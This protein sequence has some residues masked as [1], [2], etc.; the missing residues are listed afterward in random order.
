[1]RTPLVSVVLPIYNGEPFLAAALDSVLEQTY[2][3]LEIIA[4]NDGSTDGSALVLGDY[5]SRVSIVT[6]ENTGVAGARNEG[7]KR[8]SG[9]YVCFIDQDDRWVPS[10]VERQL[11]LAERDC[12]LGLVHS[13][14]AIWD[15]ERQRIVEDQPWTQRT[16]DMTGYC[17]DRLMLGNPLCNSS[18]MV[19]KSALD[20]VGYCDTSITGNT[21]PDYDLWLRIAKHW[22]F[23]HIPERLTIYRTH[24]GQGQKNREAMLKAE[25][26]VLGKHRRFE[27]WMKSRPGRIRLMNIYDELGTVHYEARRL[28]L[29]RKFFRNAARAYPSIRSLFRY[30][31]CLMPYTFGSSIRNLKQ[32][33][34]VLRT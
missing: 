30:L 21:V 5:A 12:S 31:V 34:D 32:R 14:I 27:D 10:K 29:S 23:G 1:M 15:E 6:Q 9:E 33:L 13:L 4:V 2:D 17:F 26:Q 7:L 3:K 8:A 16:P 20:E 11:A 18:V 24:A 25:L 28:E 19:R 22:R